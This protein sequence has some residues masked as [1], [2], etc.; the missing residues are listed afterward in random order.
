MFLQISNSCYLGGAALDCLLSQLVSAFGGAALFGLLLGAVI[1]TTFYIAS[2]GDLATPTVA[3]I[4]TGTVVIAMLP[5]AYER[6]ATGVVVIG[7][8]AAIWQVL[9][10]YVLSGV[11]AR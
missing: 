5:G 4:L 3:L 9:Q 1:F 7:L 11:T 8:A 2:G 10:Q 6:I